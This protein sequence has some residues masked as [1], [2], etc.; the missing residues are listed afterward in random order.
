VTEKRTKPLPEDEKVFND[1]LKRM[2]D[3]PPKQHKESKKKKDKR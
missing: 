1:T 3:T 2:L